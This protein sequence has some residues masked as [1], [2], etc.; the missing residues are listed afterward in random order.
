MVGSGPNAPNRTKPNRH[1]DRSRLA[2]GFR[3]WTT[4]SCRASVLPPALIDI[5]P[6]TPTP[7]RRVSNSP[8]AGLARRSGRIRTE[9]VGKWVDTQGRNDRV[10]PTERKDG[11][12]QVSGS[13]RLV[14]DLKA[15]QLGFATRD[16]LRGARPPAT[17]LSGTGSKSTPTFLRAW[18]LTHPSLPSARQSS[19]PA[20][21]PS[22]CPAATPAKRWW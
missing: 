15:H 14:L 21:S 3:S 22:C 2:S 11:K 7:C 9:A 12:E 1:L 8:V 16:Q 17:N 18:K 6:S 10:D 5:P 4:S 19:S 13:Q 20:R